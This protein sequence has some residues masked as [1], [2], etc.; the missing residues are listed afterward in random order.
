MRVTLTSYLTAPHSY[1]GNLRAL[2]MEI[3]TSVEAFESY[4]RFSS[5][6]VGNRAA[7]FRNLYLVLFQMKL[8]MLSLNILCKPTHSLLYRQPDNSCT[9]C[10]FFGFCLLHELTFLKEGIWSYAVCDMWKVVNIS[11]EREFNLAFFPLHYRQSLTRKYILLKIVLNCIL[12]FSVFYLG[13]A[14]SCW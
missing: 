1:F 11:C 3:N 14:Y 4:N 13:Y 7:A 9:S 12:K 5:S 6:T 8:Y 2:K 10:F